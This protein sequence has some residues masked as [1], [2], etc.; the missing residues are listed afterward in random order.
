MSAVPLPSAD[1][2]ADARARAPAAAGWLAL[3]LAAC[4]GG[5]STTPNLG[6]DLPPELVFCR[7]HQSQGQTAEIAL[8]TAQNLG[9]RRVP[10]RSGRELHVR[11][12]PGG[13][14]VVFARERS[15]GDPQSRE[16]YTAGL[17][18][19]LPELRLTANTA[20]DDAPCWSP[21]GARVLF[22]TDRDSDR[23]L[24]TTD[25]DG[26]DARPFLAADP[27]VQ[28]GDPDWS[29]ATD[30]IVFSRRETN[31][32]RRLWL[33]QGDG[34]G[35]VPLS[36]GSPAP[37]DDAGDRE[38]A[39]APDGRT[40]AFVR[41]D[42]G[43]TGRLLAIDV[44]TGQEQ[45]LL[46]PQGT[47]RL[48]RWSPAGD[49]LFCGVDEASAG[50]AGLRLVALSADGSDPLL[51]EPGG[52]WRL[53]GVD[54]LP[55]LAAR[56]P[57]APAEVVDIGNAQIQVSSGVPVLGGPQDLRAADGQAL[58]L[59]TSTFADHEIASINCRFALPVEDPLEVLALA[60]R[61]VARVSRADGDTALR[62]SLHNP[63]AGR[64]DTVAEL[65]APGTGMR[66]LE[67]ATQ[68]LAH[69]SRERDVR[70]S[71][72]GEIGQGARAE[73]HVDLVEL[74]IVRRETP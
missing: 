57:A 2:R 12:H 59:A 26:L 50:R 30:R 5:S 48:P 58:V 11:V 70:V 16:L 22:A 23:R 72:I 28:D 68:S 65:P 32:I 17:D 74:R 20:A 39:F 37:G 7:V 9:T 43:G 55:A 46:A 52:Q 66:T 8:R 15:P 49:R 67:F 19:R 38:P 4:A 73:L 63:V 42:A 27:G 45:V 34:T 62:S 6:T 53:G 24:W 13:E 18:A 35:L 56:P 61:I 29:R 54:V 1:A 33:L 71:V 31:G 14:R 60:V 51:V 3:S 47:V 69:V 40:V 36:Q 41:L 25:P 64:F 10:E 44:A 21:D